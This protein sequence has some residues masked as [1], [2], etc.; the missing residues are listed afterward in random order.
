MM[1]RTCIYPVMSLL[2][3]RLI[4]H[5]SLCM[6]C[7]KQVAIVNT[8]KWE[9]AQ[10]VT[11]FGGAHFTQVVDKK[12]IIKEFNKDV[13]TLYVVMFKC[14]STPYGEIKPALVYIAEVPI[15]LSAVMDSYKRML[16]E[17]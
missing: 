13:H 9:H 12:N 17:V 2:L 14:K 5:G 6:M 1:Q 10:V 11:A 15:P 8:I 7:L 4:E 3:L 16:T